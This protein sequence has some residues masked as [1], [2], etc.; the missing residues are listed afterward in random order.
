MQPLKQRMRHASPLEAHAVALLR[1]IKR[2]EPCVRQKQRVRMRILKVSAQRRVRPF[3]P[4]MAGLVL[5]AGAAGPFRAL[6][7][8]VRMRFSR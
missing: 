6:A 7:E 5:G 2:Y 3:W 8:R 1:S 4:A